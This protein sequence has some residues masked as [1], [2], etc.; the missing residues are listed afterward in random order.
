MHMCWST[1]RGSGPVCMHVRFW[2]CRHAHAY[3][4][5]SKHNSCV[6]YSILIFSILQAEWLHRFISSATSCSRMLYRIPSFSC[7]PVVSTPIYE[8]QCTG[9]TLIMTWKRLQAHV[10]MVKC[11]TVNE[12]CP[13]S[14]KLITL[15][16]LDSMIV[17]A[18]SCP[19]W[20]SSTGCSSTG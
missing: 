13:Q 17:M 3:T 7:C 12:E 2:T 15:T 6:L 14:N 9:K 5:L 11:P 1:T 10:L 4:Q 19:T 20:C 16:G 8:K 18:Y